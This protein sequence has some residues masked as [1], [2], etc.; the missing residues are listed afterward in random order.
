MS[1]VSSGL[2][3]PGTMRALKIASSCRA[4]SGVMSSSGV[5]PAMAAV[6]AR[7]KAF[8]SNTGSIFLVGAIS[9]CALTRSIPH[10]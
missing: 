7:R 5:C 9:L 2:V 3:V 10:P 1:M 4:C 8:M 6:T